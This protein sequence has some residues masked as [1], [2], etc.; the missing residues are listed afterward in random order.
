MIPYDQGTFGGWPFK[1][2]DYKTTIW[3]D[4]PYSQK[5]IVID[6]KGGSPVRPWGLAANW[7]VFTVAFFIAGCTAPSIVRLSRRYFQRQVTGFP[8]VVDSDERR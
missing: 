1:S 5:S 7:A 3:V 4:A 8:V 6:M 2:Y